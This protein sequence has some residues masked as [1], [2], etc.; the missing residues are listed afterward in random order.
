MYSKKNLP[1]D[2]HSYMKRSMTYSL[3]N[4]EQYHSRRG[5]EATIAKTGRLSL[6][7][8]Y[9]ETKGIK[10]NYYQLFTD[11]I[12]PLLALKFQEKKIEGCYSINRTTNKHKSYIDLKRPLQNRFTDWAPGP[13]DLHWDRSTNVLYLDFTDRVKIGVKKKKEARVLVRRNG[14]EESRALPQAS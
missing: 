11:P 7:L 9:Q 10:G 14:S 1:F 5:S 8:S 3:E 6:D 2:A 4:M 13:V 12:R